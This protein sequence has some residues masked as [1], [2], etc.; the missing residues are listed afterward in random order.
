MQAG[1]YDNKIGRFEIATYFMT[2]LGGNRK[3]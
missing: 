2:G 3:I 1:Q